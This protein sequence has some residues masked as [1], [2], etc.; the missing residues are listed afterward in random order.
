[1][2]ELKNL[3]NQNMEYRDLKYNDIPKIEEI[4]IDSSK[5][6]ANIHS[7]NTLIGSNGKEVDITYIN[8]LQ[9]LEQGKNGK[10]EFPI[11]E[12]FLHDNEWEE[13]NKFT[14]SLGKMNRLSEGIYD[15]TK[16]V[17]NIC[18]S[19]KQ[20]KSDPKYK[21]KQNPNFSLSQKIL[22]SI[23]ETNKYFD[24]IK[25]IENK[26]NKEN[27]SKIFK[28]YI[29]RRNYYTYGI[30]Y[31][32]YPSKEPILKIVKKNKE[33]YIKYKEEDFI[34]NLKIFIYLKNILDDMIQ[35]IQSDTME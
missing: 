20:I 32:L 22:D 6:I 19:L 8:Y 13:F 2:Q 3:I 27:F 4:K 21:E 26:D 28:E 17:I 18:Y 25:G 31:F 30:L 1:M 29:K 12:E 10:Y 33:T 23:L 5:I 11:Y 14:Y 35:I 9:I 16:R 34:H 15:K 24:I 7:A